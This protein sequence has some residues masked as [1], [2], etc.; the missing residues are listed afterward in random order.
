MRDGDCAE[1]SIVHNKGKELII[2]GD[3]D[4]PANDGL[5]SGRSPSM[6]PPPGRNARG[7]T[8]VKSLR[9]HS[10]RLALSDAISGASRRA[11]EHLNMRQNQLLQAPR[12]A[13]V[14]P[15]GMIPLMHPAF[16]VGPTFYA[17]LTTLIRGT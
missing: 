2:S 7:S 12:N 8:R 6:S 16:G 13:S 15:D 1:H 14:L 11:R 4:N 3:G 9:K 5:S 17:Q 10:H